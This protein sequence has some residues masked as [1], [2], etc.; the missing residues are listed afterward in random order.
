MFYFRH[1]V[2]CLTSGTITVTTF[3]PACFCVPANK[4]T[5]T[6]SQLINI[7]RQRAPNLA[8]PKSAFRDQFALLV[9][10]DGGK[11][12]GNA[13]GNSDSAPIR[14]NRL[15]VF[16]VIFQHDIFAPLIILSVQ[17]SILIKKKSMMIVRSRKADAIINPCC[18]LKGVKTTGRRAPGDS[19]RQSVVFTCDETDGRLRVGVA[20]CTGD[21]DSRLATK[22]HG[23]HR[24]LHSH[25]ASHDR[26]CQPVIATPCASAMYL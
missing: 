11:N 25:R 3:S 17:Q 1:R 4:I 15:V 7:T 18:L 23:P 20:I 13:R 21:D 16:L 6:A 8:T 5:H 19:M 10:S 12:S 22:F 14:G 2:L 26:H 9:G 24:G